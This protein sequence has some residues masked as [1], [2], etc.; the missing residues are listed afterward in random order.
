MR[1][2][3]IPITPAFGEVKSATTEGTINDSVLVQ[4]GIRVLHVDN[5]SHKLLS[6]HQV[7]EGG[8]QHHHQVGVFTNEGCRFFPVEGC[9]DALKLLSAKKQT[10]Q[11]LAQDGV[12]VYSPVANM[13]K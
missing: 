13:N 2:C 1:R 8:S 4:L 3:N 10:F 12:Y 5:M 9:G 11:G 6:V 7:R